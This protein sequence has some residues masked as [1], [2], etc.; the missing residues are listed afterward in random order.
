MELRQA[1]AHSLQASA[2]VW[3]F[4]SLIRN[5]I[6]YDRRFYKKALPL[7]AQRDA[8]RVLIQTYL[9]TFRELGVETWLM[10]GTLL[11]WWWGKKVSLPE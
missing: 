6:H 9:S 4:G 7:T 3:G 10:H 5:H 8:I 1:S 11:G 2:N